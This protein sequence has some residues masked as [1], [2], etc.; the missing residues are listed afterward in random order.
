M[1]H[2]TIRI[3]F[4]YNYCI[5]IPDR[6]Y[7]FSEIV[8]GKKVRWRSAYDQALARI[9]NEYGYGHYGPMLVTYRGVFHVMGAILFILFSILISR[10]IFG[11][12][13]ALYLLFSFVAAG[14]LYQEMYIQ[15]HTHGQLLFHSFIDWF[16][17]TIPMAIYLYAHIHNVNLSEWLYVFV[18][19]LS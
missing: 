14:I 15:K 2:I 18:D 7:P 8:N 16:S 19:T 5:T 3:R 11:S 17:W 12:D 9:Q 4:L 10:D 6:L 13:G 1:R